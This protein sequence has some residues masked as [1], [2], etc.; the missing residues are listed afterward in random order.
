MLSEIYFEGEDRALYYG[1][2]GGKS[3]SGRC[4]RMPPN[5]RTWQELTWSWA[6]STGH[7]ASDQRMEAAAKAAWPYA[8]LCAWTY[9]ND[10]DFAYDLMD[11]AVHNASEYV[12]RH[13]DQPSNKL[14]AELRAL[15]TVVQSRLRPRGATKSRMDRSRIWNRFIFARRKLNNGPLQT[16]FLGICRLSRS[17]SCTGAGSDTPGDR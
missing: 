13:P 10:H 9:L 1:Q 6:Y 2:D 11:H 16:K 17:Q 15:S 4:S 8:L 14:T 5:G 12:G 7:P 3:P